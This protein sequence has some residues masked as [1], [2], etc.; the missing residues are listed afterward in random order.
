[1]LDRVVGNV[2]A[3]LMCGGTHP[4][5]GGG[6]VEQDTRRAAIH[7]GTEAAALLAGPG[8][9]VDPLLGHGLGREGRELGEAR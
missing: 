6:V 1:M 4:E 8:S 3:Q 9:S 5:V 7:R 2:I